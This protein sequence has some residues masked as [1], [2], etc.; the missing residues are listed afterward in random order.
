[1]SFIGVQFLMAPLLDDLSLLEYHDLICMH[2]RTKP[3]CYND[4]SL[5]L[6][7]ECSDRFCTKLS[8]VLS[9]EDVASSRTSISG[10]LYKALAMAIRC[11]C[12]PESV[13]PFSPIGSKTIGQVFYKRQY[14]YT[15]AYLH[16]LFHIGLEFPYRYI[17]DHITS[18]KVYFLGHYT[19]QV[20]KLEFSIYFRSYSPIRIFPFWIG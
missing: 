18:E 17:F 14:P 5:V 11:F 19:D 12:P 15:F 2:H 7:A 10:C 1:M 4:N 6:F 20:S 16:N 3:V 8:E 13:A 9:S